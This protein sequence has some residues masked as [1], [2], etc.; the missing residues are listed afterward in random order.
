MDY[1]THYESPLGGMTMASDGE[2]L[3]G[4]WFDGQKYFAET[5]RE[6]GWK[7]RLTVCLFSKERCSGW[8]CIL[9]GR[10]RILLHR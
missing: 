10:S 9:A 6:R 3:I 5:R 8:M 1:S 2:S 4:L 7:S